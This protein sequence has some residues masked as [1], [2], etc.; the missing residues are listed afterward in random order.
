MKGNNP[1]CLTIGQIRDLIFFYYR[2][3]CFIL[4]KFCLGKIMPSSK[5]WQLS[6]WLHVGRGRDFISSVWTV[7]V[8]ELEQEK[9]LL[10]A[11]RQQVLV[12]GTSKTRRTAP[13]EGKDWGDYLI[14]SYFIRL[15]SCWTSLG[16]SGLQIKLKALS[17]KGLPKLDGPRFEVELD[18]SLK[19]YLMVE[20]VLCRNINLL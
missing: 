17:A 14:L 1:I 18:W 15:T 20:W 19:T 12:A 13:Q 16:V 2:A 6:R 10:V 7:V 4:Q 9:G 11:R 3:P 5:Y 8:L